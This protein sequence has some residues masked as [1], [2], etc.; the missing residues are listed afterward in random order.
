LS[1]QLCIHDELGQVRGLSS[2]LF[3]TIEMSASALV[4]PL[5]LIISTQA[6]DPEAL[7]SV[8]I[9]D[10]LEGKD[11]VTVCHLHAAPADSPDLFGE[12]AI[13]AAN[14]AL[15]LFMNKE[16]VLAEARRAE[17]LPGSRAAFK[18]FVLNL[19]EDAS[20]HPFLTAD[21]WRACAAPP[22]DLHY[23]EVFGG[24][25]LSERKDLTAFVLVG[26]DPV[27]GDW[28]AK[29]FFWLPAERLREQTDG[30]RLSEWADRGLIE[31]T[32]GPIIV[33]DEVARRVADIIREY[34]VKVVGFDRARIESFKMSLGK[35]GMS[36]QTIEE[37]FSAFGQGTLSM[38]PALDAVEEVVLSRKLRHG[39]NP[40]LNWCVSNAA[41]KAGEHGAR[42]LTRMRARARIDGIVAL[43]MALGVVPK[44]MT[45]TIDV[46]ALIG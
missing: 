41:V 42:K 9:D 46:A 39:D 18:N 15:D 12:E 30:D 1:P 31:L 20:G 38:T 32:D 7:L 44:A 33:F 14:P 28:S 6:A 29:C 26:Q 17:R 8:L 16:A 25:D 35:A 5:T 43:T 23:C 22:R 2:E 34:E 21:V 40:V 24:L 27:E 37:K 13:A 4:H 11:P 10:A 19:R 3:D 36:A 45:E